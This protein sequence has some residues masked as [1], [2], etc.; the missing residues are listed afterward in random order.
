MNP[1]TIGFRN[2]AIS[3]PNLDQYKF[4]AVRLDGI[5]RVK[6]AKMSAIIKNEVYQK[7]EKFTA[8]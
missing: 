5:A 1:K 4:K 6:T 7:I 8:P 2:L 3:M